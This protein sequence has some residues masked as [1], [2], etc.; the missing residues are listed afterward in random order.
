MLGEIQFSR[1]F[2]HLYWLHGQ[3]QRAFDP[4]RIPAGGTYKIKLPEIIPLKSHV[5][6]LLYGGRYLVYAIYRDQSRVLDGHIRRR[7]PNMWKGMAIS[8][9]VII[10]KFHDENI[11]QEE[12]NEAFKLSGWGPPP[13]QDK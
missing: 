11:S 4:I 7:Y 2:R 10:K 12:L 8:N 9:T 5:G 6:M 3:D 1:L 13:D